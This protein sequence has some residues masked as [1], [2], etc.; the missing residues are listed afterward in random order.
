MF[1]LSRIQLLKFAAGGLVVIS[2]LG[3]PARAD[4]AIAALSMLSFGTIGTRTLAG[5]PH[6]FELA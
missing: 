1:P 3:P 5:Q 2:T 4:A 6:A